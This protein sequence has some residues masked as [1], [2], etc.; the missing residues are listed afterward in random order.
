LSSQAKAE[1]ETR[2]L[3]AGFSLKRYWVVTSAFPFHAC[4][5]QAQHQ[6]KKGLLHLYLQQKD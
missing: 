2:R 6:C 4:G 1:K 3:T 5:A